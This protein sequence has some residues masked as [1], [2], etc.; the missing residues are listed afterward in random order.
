MKRF[1]ILN[2]LVFSALVVV[3]CGN[4]STD[5]PTQSPIATSSNIYNNY[6]LNI[7]VQDRRGKITSSSI[8]SMTMDVNGTSISYVS[9]LPFSKVGSKWTITLP[10][11]PIDENLTFTVNGFNSISSFPIYKAT[12]VQTLFPYDNNVSL[13]LVKTYNDSVNLVS[14]GSTTI[15]DNNGS[16]ILR[17]NFN[18]NGGGVFNY[19]IQSNDI[20]FTPNIG[21][22]YVGQNSYLDINYTT[23]LIAKTYSN[24]ITFTDDTNNTSI[25]NF[26]IIISTTTSNILLNLAPDINSIVANFIDNNTTV[27]SANVTDPEG[28]NLNYQWSLYSNTYNLFIDNNITNTNTITI[29]GDINNTTTSYATLTVTDSGGSSSSTVYYLKQ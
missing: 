5:K 25:N 14:I 8:T 7:D 4:R 29:L 18:N 10:S 20:N 17:F 27:L 13:N 1:M 19:T 3:G 24:S 6:S 12:K 23:P 15:T 22:V 11:L 21:T 26:D 16:S 2:A 28:N 9:G